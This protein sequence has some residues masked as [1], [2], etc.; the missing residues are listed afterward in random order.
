MH[1]KRPYKPRSEMINRTNWKPEKN[2][3]TIQVRLPR[4]YV[5]MIA[6]AF[7]EMGNPVRSLGELG[8]RGLVEFANILASNGVIPRIEDSSE[9]TQ[10]LQRAG[11]GN[12]NAGGRGVA[13]YYK[14]LRTE[15]A[16]ELGF[17]PYE[18][19]KVRVERKDTRS[20]P[21]EE[22]QIKFVMEQTMC[23]REEARK[24]LSTTQ[25]E[26]NEQ[27]AIEKSTQRDKK[28]KDALAQGPDPS[29]IIEE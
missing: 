21:S 7:H 17:D 19:A 5:A 2:D 4:K 11:L 14:N 13:N 26:F 24:K 29:S 23:S 9:A 12:L 10:A 20:G 15:Q 27:E 1:K 28:E 8:R 16:M 6:T 18:P 25:E 22:Q 3:A